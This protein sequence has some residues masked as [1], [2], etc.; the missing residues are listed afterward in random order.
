MYE[1]SNIQTDKNTKNWKGMQ[2]SG[3]LLVAEETG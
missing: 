3:A 2:W 1:N